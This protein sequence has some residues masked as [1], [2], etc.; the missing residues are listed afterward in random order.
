MKG[1]KSAI[2]PHFR[3]IRHQ[4]V[5]ILPLSTEVPSL[6]TEES[7]SVISEKNVWL[8]PTLK[9]QPCIQ[10]V[11]TL[12][13]EQ[14]HEWL[15]CAHTQHTHAHG[16][17]SPPPLS[18]PH[19]GVIDSFESH[20]PMGLGN[21]SVLL[22]HQLTFLVMSSELSLPCLRRSGFCVE[23][24]HFYQDCKREPGIQGWKWISCTA[25][26]SASNRPAR[27]FSIWSWQS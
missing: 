6:F 7:N 5:F 10:K 19:G 21:V 16:G 13:I 20:T 17:F 26:P 27:C 18:V 4:T 24:W 15:I 25:E 3:K 12:H 14:S 11:G 23:A 1:G 8:P 2:W 22:S 9:D